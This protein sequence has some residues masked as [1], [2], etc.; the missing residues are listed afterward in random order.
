MTPECSLHTPPSAS[1]NTHTSANTFAR[2][3]Q[4]TTANMTDANKPT[5]TT[6][7]RSSGTHARGGE[8]RCLDDV[9]RRLETAFKRR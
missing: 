6:N 3:F 4:T 2:T 1:T 7:T 8:R 5:I 9:S